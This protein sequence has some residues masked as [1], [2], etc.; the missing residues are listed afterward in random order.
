MIFR[1]DVN[2]GEL[3]Y[4]D[5]F[6]ILPF[7]NTIDHVIMKGEEIREILEEVVGDLCPNKTCYAQG[8]LQVSGIKMTV[9]VTETNSGN[10]I[11]KLKI[12]CS[13]ENEHQYCDIEPE[14]EYNVAMC[15]FLA[16]QLYRDKTNLSK[17]IKN[18]KVG[19]PDHQCLKS[20]IENNKVISP[21]IEGRIVIQYLQKNK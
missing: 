21:K 9:L 1:T 12:L 15:S 10:R 20:Y 19:I 18:R 7:N 3:T 13:P 16:T 8:F 11:Q 2:I 17:L 6:A 4:E 5:I 14:K